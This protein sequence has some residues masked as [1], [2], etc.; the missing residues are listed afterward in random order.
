MWVPITATRCPTVGEQ[1]KAV[2]GM[3]GGLGEGGGG[4]SHVDAVVEAPRVEVLVVLPDR[5]VSLR[6]GGRGQ[7][8]P[9]SESNAL[10]RSSRIPVQREPHHHGGGGGGGGGLEQQHQTISGRGGF[11]PLSRFLTGRVFEMRR[12]HLSR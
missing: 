3:E 12:S 10:C 9:G 7:Q 6:T 2:R 11:T 1:G 4:A 5:R 8:E